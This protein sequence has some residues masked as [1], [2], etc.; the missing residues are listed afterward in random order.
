MENWNELIKKI[1]EGMGFSDF[2]IEVDEEHRHAKIFIYDN[3]GLIKDNLPVLVESFNHL[4]QLIAQ[5]NS[6]EAIF[7]DVNNYRKE[8]ETIIIEL[9]KAAA[10]KALATKQAIS[11]PAMNSYERRIVHV[12]LAAHPEVQTESQ[13]TG[14]ERYVVIK[15]IL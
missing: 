6:R 4:F 3:P 12:E 5:K 11:L 2:K 13:E 1:V 10:R 15:P 9:A 7:V 8:R 14:K